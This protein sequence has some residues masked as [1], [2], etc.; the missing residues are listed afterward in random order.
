ML[1]LAIDTSWF[2]G[3]I[4][5]FE[6]ETPLFYI[7]FPEERKHAIYLPLYVQKVLNESE[8]KLEDISL[9]SV[10]LGPGSFTGLRVGIS[11]SKGLSY[12]L[13]IPIKG[14]GSLE[15]IATN[16]KG[17]RVLPTVRLRKDFYVGAIFEGGVPPYRLSEI[18]SGNLSFFKNKEGALL[19]SESEQ[20][21]PFLILRGIARLS[22]YLFEMNGSDN[23]LTL[24]PIY[25]G[26]GQPT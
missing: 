4:G 25:I 2:K 24:S 19:I 16:F 13:N 6:D 23:P 7:T 12:T 18:L 26:G 1:I 17:Q 5:L 3:G 11:L 15:A 8:K 9:I 22:K 20:N 21:Y 10:A 14:V